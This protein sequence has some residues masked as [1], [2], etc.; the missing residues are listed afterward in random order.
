M[1]D[2]FYASR[3]GYIALLSALIYRF[4]SRACRRR[5]R[6]ALLALG[7]LSLLALQ[8]ISPYLIERFLSIGEASELGSA[9]RLRMWD[10]IWSAFLHGPIVFGYGAG[11]GVNAVEWAGGITVTESNLHS[12]FA[13]ALLDFGIVGLA[14]YL[15]VLRRVLRQEWKTGI[16][17]PLAGYVLVHV[18]AGLFQFRGGEPLFWF[19]FGL[20]EGNLRQREQQNGKPET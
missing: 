12:Y 5:E 20:Y 19:V 13:Q 15:L 4:F 7:V 1:M 6:I 18:V 9:G 17:D 3:T 16:G 11:R 14:S 10:H 8:W 2:S